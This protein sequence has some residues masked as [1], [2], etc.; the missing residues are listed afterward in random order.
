MMRTGGKSPTRSMTNESKLAQDL[1]E[2]DAREPERCTSLMLKFG[3]LTSTPR[4]A[5][6]ERREPKTHGNR[7]F[8][9]G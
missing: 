9:S 5:Q 1:P 8:G 3:T 4:A 6:S 7:M 2:P